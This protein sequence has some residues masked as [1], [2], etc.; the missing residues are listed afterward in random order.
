MTIIG[1][2]SKGKAKRRHV[3]S[4]DVLRLR[5]SVELLVVDEQGKSIAVRMSK[6]R[7]RRIAQELYGELTKL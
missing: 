6:E 4:C 1:P 3:V 5:D 2:H 7:A